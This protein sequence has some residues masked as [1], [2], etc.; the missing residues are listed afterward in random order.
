MLPAPP[1]LVQPAEH[2]PALP[3]GHADADLVAWLGDRYEPTPRDLEEAS[4][5]EALSHPTNRRLF[6]AAREVLRTDGT[7]GLF[8]LAVAVA[9]CGSLAPESP[10]PAARC[11][12]APF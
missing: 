11:G 5:A 3:A 1:A 12:E 6:D 7:H 2:I 4:L 9:E 8:P 10:A